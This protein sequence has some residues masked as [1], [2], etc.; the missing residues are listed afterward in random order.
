M[1]TN[2]IPLGTI[3]RVLTKKGISLDSILDS[4][5]QDPE[6]TQELYKKYV[7][8]EFKRQAEK[9]RMINDILTAASKASKTPIEKLEKDPELYVQ[10]GKLIIEWIDQMFFWDVKDIQEMIEE[11]EEDE[12]ED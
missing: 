7:E 9:N 2:N 5:N 10:D 4:W 3:C 6:L 11:D 1:E 8:K 12:D